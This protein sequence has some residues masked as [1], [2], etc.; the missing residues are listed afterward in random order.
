MTQHQNMVISCKPFVIDEFLINEYDI[1]PGD[2]CIHAV[3][4]LTFRQLIIP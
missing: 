2:I 3:T 4:K 1:S